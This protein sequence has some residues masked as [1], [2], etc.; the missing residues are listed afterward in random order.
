MRTIVIALGLTVVLTGC[1]TEGSDERQLNSWIGATVN[2]LARLWGAPDREQQFS[3]GSRDLIYTTHRV[4]SIPIP[5]EPSTWRDIHR[6]CEL[7]FHIGQD[8]RIERVQGR[9]KNC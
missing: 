9:G 6:Y 2:E 8:E 7:A 5:G 4:Y 3:D 1:A